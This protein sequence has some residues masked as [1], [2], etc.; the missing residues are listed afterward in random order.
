MFRSLSFKLVGAF[1]ILMLL[2]LGVVLRVV[3]NVVEREMGQYTAARTEF[4]RT[5]IPTIPAA[6]T[7]PAMPMVPDMQEDSRTRI[8]IPRDRFTPVLP[9]DFG[10]AIGEVVIEAAEGGGTGRQFLADV[11]RAA[12]VG[13]LVAGIAA[14]TLGTIAF[15]QFTRPLAKLR[16]AVQ[17]LADGDLSVRIPV[18]SKDEVGKVSAA[19]NHMASRLEH[20][21]GLRQRMVAD[22]AHELRTPLS[23][24]KGNIE[25]MIDG[26]L[27]PTTAELSEL[28]DEV[29]RLTRLIEDLRLLSSADA[30][31]LEL[32][33]ESM[34]ARKLISRVTGLM[35]PLAEASSI[36]LKAHLPQAPIMVHGDVDRLQQALT[37][38]V[39][40]GIRHTP[41]GGQ[42]SVA[43]SRSDQAAFI[44]VSDNGSGIGAEDLP[45]VFERF[46]RGDRSRS[47]NS[48]GSGLGLSIVKQIAELHGGT[49][50]AVSLDSGGSQFSI[51]LPVES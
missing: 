32:A 48:G 27:E 15:R 18:R 46:W 19:F 25:A 16:T 20:Q 14:I 10:P 7:L 33:R 1:V 49:V 51:S 11:E 35:A 24:M 2:T 3:V 41:P 4:A 39:D 47:R 28:H 37:N 44:S 8:I 45:H 40:N 38:L 23:V 36:Q 6:P 9:R 43:V 42:V 5:L 31:Q 12:Q 29:Q 22:V 50:Q 30:G 21:E 13:I 34:D 26:L 17:S